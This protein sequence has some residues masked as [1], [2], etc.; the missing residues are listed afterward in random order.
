LISRPAIEH[1]LARAGRAEEPVAGLASTLREGRGLGLRSEGTTEEGLE[2]R[3]T[4]GIGPTAIL[5]KH[6]EGQVGLPFA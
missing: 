3:A 6:L 5:A 4:L 2:G 1:L